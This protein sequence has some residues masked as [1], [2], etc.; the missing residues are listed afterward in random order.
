MLPSISPS[1]R[2]A[3]A[4]IHSEALPLAMDEGSGHFGLSYPRPD[5]AMIVRH[6]PL[7][8]FY[9]AYLRRL[10]GERDMVMVEARSDGGTYQSR[11]L[12]HLAGAC[13]GKGQPWKGERARIAPDGV[14]SCRQV[15]FFDDVDGFPISTNFPL[16][17]LC[18]EGTNLLELRVQWLATRAADPGVLSGD[19][20]C[21]TCRIC[22]AGEVQHRAAE[23]ATCPHC[24]STPAG[25]R[26]A[27]G[28]DPRN[29][30]PRGPSVWAVRPLKA[31]RLQD[32]PGHNIYLKPDESAV[33]AAY[34]MAGLDPGCRGRS[35]SPTQQRVAPPP[36]QAGGA[37]PTSA[38][39]GMPR[40]EAHLGAR[41]RARDQHAAPTA[42]S[43]R[44][45]RSRGEEF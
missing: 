43:H 35:F 9:Q 44:G 23:G 14:D 31:N 26:P 33:K 18:V 19:W 24:G 30:Q 1:F 15:I 36:D 39:S 28:W 29:W 45:I 11:Y 25:T 12:W 38:V 7:F 4:G 37:R 5:G 41:K 2:I 16:D 17:Q 13:V 10:S 40:T 27:G 8:P 6:N 3:P 32:A 42:L 22:V 20:A 34:R 21:P